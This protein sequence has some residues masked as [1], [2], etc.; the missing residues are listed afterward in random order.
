MTAFR[1]VCWKSAPW[2]D[3]GALRHP[4]NTL[5]AYES[6]PKGSVL[7]SRRERRVAH[8]GRCLNGRLEGGL[9]PGAGRPSRSAT[10]GASLREEL[11]LVLSLNFEALKI[12]PSINKL[13]TIV[14][15][16][17]VL[18]SSI[19]WT[20]VEQGWDTRCTALWNLARSKQFWLWA[21]GVGITCC[22]GYSRRGWRD[23]Q[24]AVHELDPEFAKW[25]LCSFGAR[26]ATC[27]VR[28]SASFRCT[29][30]YRIACS[31]E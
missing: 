23:G 26:T 6:P 1:A 19:G 18:I 20:P 12:F 28:L 4:V 29:T 17:L 9:L 16:C 11:V 10:G 5:R 22:P 30:G 15:P 13:K 2:N 3:C 24:V 27:P 7:W 21:A 31:S 25:R 14:L 8:R